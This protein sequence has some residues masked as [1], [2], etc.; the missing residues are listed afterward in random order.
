MLT[1]Q[2]LR[3]VVALTVDVDAILTPLACF[4]YTANNSTDNSRNVAERDPTWNSR[5]SSSS[6][7]RKCCYWCCCPV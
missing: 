1:D 4:L 5:H 3:S 7:S 2:S 6:S